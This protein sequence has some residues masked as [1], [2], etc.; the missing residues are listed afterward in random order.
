MRRLIY[1]SGPISDGGRATGPQRLRNVD[2]AIDYAVDLIERGFGIICPQLTEFIER[3]S[4]R[5]FDHS[6]WMEIDLPIVERCDAV[7]RLP[8]E[9][10]GSDIEVNHAREIGIPVLFS[11]AELEE[12]R[13]AEDAIDSDDSDGGSDAD[14]QADD[15]NE[16][17]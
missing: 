15:Q 12:W 3:R 8:G 17:A 5:R 6:V 4:G 10:K 16:A 1:I 13:K 7:L 11:V 14:D 9:S 2:G